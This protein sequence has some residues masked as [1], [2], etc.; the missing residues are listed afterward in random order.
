MLSRCC[1][2]K[3]E[4][5]GTNLNCEFAAQCARERILKIGQHCAVTTKTWWLTFLDHPVYDKG[6]KQN[7]SLNHTSQ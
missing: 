4:I 5:F 1:I 2:Y 6:V 7:R 3:P